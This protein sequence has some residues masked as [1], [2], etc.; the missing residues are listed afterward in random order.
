MTAPFWGFPLTGFG[1]A[2]RGEFIEKADRHMVCY[3]TWL[4]DDSMRLDQ[5]RNAIEEDDGSNLSPPQDHLS[6]L[7]PTGPWLAKTRGSASGPR[8]GR[9][10]QGRMEQNS[11]G[12][13]CMPG[14]LKPSQ[15]HEE[16]S[17]TGTP[18]PG[19]LHLTHTGYKSRERERHAPPLC[20][21]L[22]ENPTTSWEGKARPS[23]RRG[24]CAEDCAYAAARPR[25]KE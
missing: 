9:A 5:Q 8:S 12:Q 25:D 21:P 23:N 14:H 6:L 10:G 16:A 3:Y 17:A 20:R 11:A 13:S 24:D 7:C 18:F 2:R 19:P 15:T 1:G 4:D 22:T